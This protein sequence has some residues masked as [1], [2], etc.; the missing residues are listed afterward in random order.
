MDG[1]IVMYD[2]TRIKTFAAV[3][4]WLT[5][6]DRFADEDSRTAIILVG[7]KCDVQEA[8]RVSCLF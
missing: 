2:V 4:D 5:D 3:R 8:D 1:F 6:I 7:N